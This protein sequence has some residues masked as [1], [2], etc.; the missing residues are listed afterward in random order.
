[1][2]VLGIPVLA[3]AA[4]AI[5]TLVRGSYLTTVV[6]LGAT[7]FWFMPIVIWQIMPKFVA[8]GTFDS[9]G[10]TIRLDK[11][12]DRLTL[13]NMFAGTVSLGLLAAFGS[14]GKLD[15]PLPPDIASLYSLVFAGPAL[16]CLGLIAMIVVRPGVCRVRL[17]PEGFEFAEAFTRK[18]GTWSEVVDMTEE[19]PSGV[20][21]NSPIVMV[22][23]GGETKMLKEA[24][25]FTPN[26]AVLR[27]HVRFYWQHPERR[28]ELTDGQ[29]LEKLRS[30]Q[31]LDK[32]AP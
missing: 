11:R 27:E 22:M 29:A 4:W 21:A 1:M 13:I 19:A 23:A 32:H 26:P 30:Q 5:L 15:I 9:S 31:L 2:V 25:V 24:M 18:R 16:A 10:T 17:T 8:W 12:M 14:S 28:D 20:Y 6:A 7:V 3:C